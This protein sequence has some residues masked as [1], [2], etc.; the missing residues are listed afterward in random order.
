MTAVTFDHL[1]QAVAFKFQL[2]A[3]DYLG[4]EESKTPG[5][6][7]G[8]TSR[9]LP[10][11]YHRVQ[12]FPVENIPANLPAVYVVTRGIAPDPAPWRH[13]NTRDVWGRVLIEVVVQ[14]GSAGRTDYDVGIQPRLYLGAMLH[15]FDE[16]TDLGGGLVING[17]R[18]PGLID[19]PIDDNGDVSAYCSLT[20]EID[21]P[22]VDGSLSFTEP[23]SS[24]PDPGTPPR[25][26]D[27][28]PTILT[29]I[30]SVETMP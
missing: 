3:N 17:W 1:E 24:V 26:P 2:W 15:L 4:V 27:V 7:V 23:P 25:N 16:Q 20:L 10:G 21:C 29:L 6:E 12:D 22:I 14:S 11:S 30:T 8:A 9:P 19:E 5:V 28:P 13:A 18:D